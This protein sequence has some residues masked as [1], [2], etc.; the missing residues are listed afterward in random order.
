MSSALSKRA[1]LIQESANTIDQVVSVLS[2]H[3]AESRK[4]TGIAK[5]TREAGRPAA[6]GAAPKG[7][8]IPQ[9]EFDEVLHSACHTHARI[10]KGFE[11]GVSDFVDQY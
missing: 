3:R 10:V 4:D 2:H 11:V 5:A 7:V 6:A 1:D 8:F 9:R